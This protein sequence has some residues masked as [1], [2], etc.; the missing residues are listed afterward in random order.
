MEAVNATGYLIA[1]HD[2][3]HHVSVMSADISKMQEW[4]DSR[5]TALSN[6]HKFTLVLSGIINESQVK[7]MRIK[8]LV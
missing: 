4:I 2:G 3:P 5:P 8:D 7:I 6:P 1:V